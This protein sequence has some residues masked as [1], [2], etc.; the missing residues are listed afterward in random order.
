MLY[1][2]SILRGALFILASE[3]LLASAGALI[4]WLATD[5]PNEMI[6]FFRN[7]FGL[8]ALLPLLL[9][10]RRVSL[11]TQIFPLHL[12]RGLAGLAAMYCFYYAIGHIKLADAMVLKLTTPIF[13]PMIAWFWLRERLPGLALIALLIGFFGVLLVLRPGAEF[14]WVVLVAVAG[15]GFAAVAKV[16]IRRLSDTEPAVRTVFYFA[17]VGAVVSAVPLLWA[18][19]TPT[20][21]QWLF[22]LALGPLASLAQWCMTRGYASAPASQVGI[23]TYSAVLFGAAYG[24]WLWG[25][26]WDALSMAG[27][28]LIAVAGALAL[29]AKR[30]KPRAED[31]L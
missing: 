10:G 15:S 26:I 19:Q 18:W 7:L 6:V 14:N 4:K 9:I 17:A 24:W 27:A 22:L 31:T 8:A 11:R 13:I 2:Q 12:L 23:F 29:R 28:I 5:V 25:E 16:T 1:S 21:T 3:F 20:R 30:Q